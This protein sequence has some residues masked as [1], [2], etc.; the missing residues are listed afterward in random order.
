M[1]NE[2]TINFEKA[3]HKAKDF[4]SDIKG[5][6]INLSGR[7]LINWLNFDIERKEEY[8]DFFDLYISFLENLFSEN[9]VKYR[10]RINKQTGVIED[11]EKIN[12]E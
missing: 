6:D 4:I 11:V 10:V 3:V 5:L 7:K 1:V 9:R 8:D 2:M 12:T